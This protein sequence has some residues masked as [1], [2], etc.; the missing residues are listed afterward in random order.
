MSTIDL[1]PLDEF[2]TYLMRPGQMLCFH[3]PTLEKHGESL[4]RLAAQGL[5]KKERFAGGYSLTAAGFA[6]MQNGPENRRLPR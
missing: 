3:G 6:A 2:R 1:T 4:R 5:L